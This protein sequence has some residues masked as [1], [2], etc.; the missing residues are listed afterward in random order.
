MFSRYISILSIL[1]YSFTTNCSKAYS[2]YSNCN[3]GVY[4]S[5]N[6][7]FLTFT[8]SQ[9]TYRFINSLGYYQE[10]ESDS[11]L[12]YCEDGR[13]RYKQ[14]EYQK[15]PLRVINTKFESD[16]VEL[17][18]QLMMPNN[19]SRHTPLVVY[20][21]G[22]E[23]TGWIGSAQEP[24][25]LVARGISVFVFDKRGT[26]RSGGSYTQNI[27]RLAK[28]VV[29]A[30]IEAKRLSL[31]KFSKFGI[32]GLS[33]GGWVAPLAT[34]SVEV[35]FIVVGYGLASTIAEEDADQV[36]L[37]LTNGGYGRRE[38]EIGKK[39]TDLT[40]R[41]AKSKYRDGI[42]QLMILKNKYNSEPWFKLIR[43]GYTGVL[44]NTKPE[45]LLSKGI[46]MYDSLS[47]DWSL[48]PMHVLRTTE[49]P[50]F[51]A[52]AEKDAEAPIKRTLSRLKILQNEGK[53]ISI[54]VFP[55]SD[56]GMW[57]LPE[58]NMIAPGYF[59]EVTE[60]IKDQNTL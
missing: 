10:V 35:D 24:F 8:R 60:F 37:Q 59:E 23:P 33:Q 5:E 53:D 13:L 14:V 38:I 49:V 32:V 25:Q 4:D 22:S 43:G 2:D 7:E 47:I 48:D 36:T 3:P 21:H 34:Q 50:Q 6:G 45:E 29:A 28:D 54:R 26:G 11:I 57:V 51:W 52:L 41:M 42:E 44:I 31:G 20:A 40:A 19:V 30:S 16:D 39:I 12:K 17:V 18:G 27:P 1:L 56:H 46:P 55:N 15:R 9:N 58:K